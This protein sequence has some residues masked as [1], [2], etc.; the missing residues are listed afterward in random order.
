MPPLVNV[1]KLLKDVYRYRIWKVVQVSVSTEVVE[2]DAERGA[3]GPRV[4]EVARRHARHHAAQPAGQRARARPLRRAGARAQRQVPR[5]RLRQ[6][7][8]RYI[9]HITLTL[10]GPFLIL[11]SILK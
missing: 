9:L 10:Q 11:T 8:A 2:G 4:R 1:K 7:A 5:R 3:Q 6:P